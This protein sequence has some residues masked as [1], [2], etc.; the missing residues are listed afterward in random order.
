MKVQDKDQNR[1]IKLRLAKI[2]ETVGQQ[3]K[4]LQ[5]LK[6]F[7]DKYGLKF[8]LILKKSSR[9]LNEQ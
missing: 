7:C 3:D 9:L 2:L 4:A 1:Q 6:N 5:V 8:F